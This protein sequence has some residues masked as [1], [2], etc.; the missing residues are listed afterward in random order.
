MTDYARLV[1]EISKIHELLGQLS[2]R[3]E[4][5]E[6]EVFPNLAGDILQTRVQRVVAKLDHETDVMG[7]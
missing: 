6:M 4:D 1:K 7:S 5:L 2:T 3:V